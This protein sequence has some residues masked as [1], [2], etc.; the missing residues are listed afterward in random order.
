MKRSTA[1]LTTARK[2]ELSCVT[3]ATKLTPASDDLMALPYL[4]K[5]V[6]ELLRFD[7][8]LPEVVREC[9]KDAVVPLSTPVM[10]RDGKLMDSIV[11]SKGT[12]FVVRECP[13][14]Q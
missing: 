3:G 6:R 13:Q 14:R 10:G 11:V 5:F 8:P 7:P 12:E 9:A 4:D 1:Y 2:R